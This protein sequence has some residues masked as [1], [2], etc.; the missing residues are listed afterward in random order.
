MRKVL[1]PVLAAMAALLALP[2]MAGTLE[3]VAAFEQP[4]Q[5]GRL[6]TL[7]ALLKREKLPYQIQTFEGGRDQPATGYNV[8]I[9]LGS[10]DRDILLTAHYDAKVLKDGTLAGAV[11]DNA[12]SVVGLIEAA[13]A[14]KA[15]PLKHHRLR[16]VFFD[17]EELGLLGSRAYAAGPDGKR[18]DAVINFDINGYGDTAFFF[19]PEQQ[20]LAHAV[21]TGCFLAAQDCVAFRTYPASDH[22]PFVAAGVSATS[23]SILPAREVH[24]FW[25]MMNAGQTSGLS[26]DFSLGLFK[27]MHT[28]NDRTE[29]V[30][31]EAIARATRLAVEV[32]RAAD[33]PVNPPGR[34][35]NH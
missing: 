6:A 13:S 32:A 29:A 33:A 31:P 34:P 28:A 27:F 17:Q 16:I 30:E 11:V 22:R 5:A 2:A 19:D 21:R 18:I 3:D 15:K 25:L 24:Q 7:E 14:F 4:T 23:I 10:G 20:G 1:I 35:A 26:N 12:A 8:V 9:T